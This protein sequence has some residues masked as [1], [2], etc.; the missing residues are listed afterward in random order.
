MKEGSTQ[1][2]LQTHSAFINKQKKNLC[3]E[4]ALFLRTNVLSLHCSSLTEK[5][6]CLVIT[7]QNTTTIKN[8]F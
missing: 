4:N 6:I 3:L 7:L 8:Y 1:G 5:R 2:L